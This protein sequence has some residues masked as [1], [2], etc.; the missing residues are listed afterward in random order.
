MFLEE[1]HS[2]ILG[3]WG[4]K[5]QFSAWFLF[6]IQLNKFRELYQ[7][8]LGRDVNEVRWEHKNLI[9]Y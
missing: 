6:T 9:L 3:V 5:H 2:S 8:P 4:R 7:K 1:K